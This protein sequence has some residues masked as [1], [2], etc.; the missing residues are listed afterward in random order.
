MA[1]AGVSGTSSSGRFWLC[2]QCNRHVPLRLESCRCGCVRP[3]GLAAS[4]AA[5]PLPDSPTLPPVLAR[6]A[7]AASASPDEIVYPNERTLFA[8]S[9]VISIGF[10]LFLLVGTFGL[11]LVYALIFFVFYLFAQSGLIAYIKGNAVRITPQQ[12]PDLH[13]RL[14]ASCQ[15]LGMSAVP[16]RQ[17]RGRSGR[18][19]NGRR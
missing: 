16:A 11:A 8:L 15:R 12:Y 7:V 13:Q 2:P 17:V 1:Q 19:G 6:T 5:P 14:A 4:P 10:W 18:D 3:E 9:L